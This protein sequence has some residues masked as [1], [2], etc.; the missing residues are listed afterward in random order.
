MDFL[1]LKATSIGTNSGY[2]FAS[3]VT[4]INYIAAHRKA[5]IEIRRNYITNLNTY[6]IFVGQPSTGKSPAI[7]AAV[8]QPFSKLNMTE[9]LISS[10]TSSGLSKLLANNNAAYIVNPEISDYL[11]KVLKNN[12]ENYSGDMELLCKLYSGE[13]CCLKY[14]TENSRTIKEDCTLCILGIS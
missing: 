4:T 7:K 1:K 12:D 6:F 14:S 13:S 8:V 5:T 11:L 9:E 3:L 10:S 2:V